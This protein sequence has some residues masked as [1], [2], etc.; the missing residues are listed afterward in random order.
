[1]RAALAAQPALGADAGAR[2]GVGG[3]TE[4]V[5]V[6]ASAAAL[7]GARARAAAC[8]LPAAREVGARAYLQCD[9]EWLPFADGSFDLVLSSLALHWVNDLP[10]ALAEARRV[11]RPDGVFIAAM[12]GGDTLGELR[13]SFAMAEQERDGGVSPHVSPMA[14]VADVGQLLQR[15]GFALPTVDTDHIL[16]E[17]A[18]RGARSRARRR[19]AA[20]DP[21][22]RAR[23][24]AR[25]GTPTRSC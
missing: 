10:R 8:G 21:R 15:A 7:R 1:M 19:L 3:V 20:R 5:Q 18:R 6:D 23:G 13:A 11:L 16:V 24:R 22:A 4:L 25:A 9:E 2:G 14:H 12:L 17:C